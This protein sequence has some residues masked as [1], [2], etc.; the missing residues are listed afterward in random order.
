[1]SKNIKYEFKVASNENVAAVLF[2]TLN[3]VNIEEYDKQCIVTNI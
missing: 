2:L 1:M 3:E